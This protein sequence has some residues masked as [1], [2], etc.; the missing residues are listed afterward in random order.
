MR[1]RLAVVGAI[2]ALAAL[3]GCG[4]DDEDSGGLN[5]EELD[6]Q[7]A[8]ICAKGKEDIE[9]LDTPSDEEFRDDPEKA[10]A[11]IGELVRLADENLVKLRAL[12]PEE[13]LK[14][15]YVAYTGEVETSRDFLEDVRKKALARDP[16]GYEAMVQEASTGA[17]DK[18]TEAAALKAGL[19]GCAKD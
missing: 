8:A 5:A 4:G 14:A 11:Y 15:D 18:A 3:G 1:R 12:E 19:K 2:G 10:A 9:A 17:R 16:S 6:K 7:S 13:D